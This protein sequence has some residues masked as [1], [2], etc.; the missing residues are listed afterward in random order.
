MP[1][2]PKKAR[3]LPSSLKNPRHA[4][5]KC[6]T[7]A[8]ELAGYKRNG[9][10][11]A[12]LVDSDPAE[13][14]Q[15]RTRGLIPWKPGQSGNPA[16]RQKGSRNKFSEAFLQD[17]YLVWLEEGEQALRT[18]A[19]KSPAR[20]IAVAAALIPQHFKLEQEHTIAGLSV[21][22]LREK[23][24]EARQRLIASGVELP[25]IDGE[26]IDGKAGVAGQQR[27]TSNRVALLG[28]RGAMR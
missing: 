9:G 18:A 14:K 22:E 6:A 8:Y 15:S 11:A 24:A 23:L 3:G 12:W 27:R 20:Y 2:A 1:F 21:E 7:D 19:R 26:V 17:F 28:H 25:V 16:G 10:N 4:S 13:P 5:G